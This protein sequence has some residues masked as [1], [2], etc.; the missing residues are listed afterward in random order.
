MVKKKNLVIV[1]SILC[2]LLLV[3]MIPFIILGIKTNK[4]NN[5]YKYLISENKMVEAIIE[6]VP[7]VKQEISCG[8]AIIDMLSAYYGNH[9]SEEDLYEANNHKITT[10]STKGFVEEIS[11]TLNKSC[12]ALT[13]LK[14]DELLTSINNS[15]K[16]G[17]PVA[18]EW[19]AKLDNEWTLHWSVVTGMDNNHIYINNPYGYKESLSYEE[20]ISRMDFSAYDNMSIWFKFGFAFGLFSKNTIIVIK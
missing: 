18:I 17:N 1:L 3:I 8:Y 20:F 14:N 19:A 6:D 4:I 9:V 7:L 16:A 12:T 11:K 2:A 10:S 13:Y 15:L 5:D